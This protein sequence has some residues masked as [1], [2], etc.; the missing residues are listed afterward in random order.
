[1]LWVNT[2]SHSNT[3]CIFTYCYV[4]GAH[5]Q[6]VYV[7]PLTKLHP[8]IAQCSIHCMCE[9]HD[10]LII[11]QPSCEPCVLNTLNNAPF[12]LMSM[13]PHLMAM[14]IIKTK[15]LKTCCISLLTYFLTRNNYG[16]L[17]CE[18]RVTYVYVYISRAIQDKEQVHYTHTF[19]SIM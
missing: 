15:H 1:V 11:T 4:K 16:E 19:F 13:L 18:L 8:Y 5:L 2:S 10:H 12:H 14:C 3:L 7:K 17:V 9:F 6:H